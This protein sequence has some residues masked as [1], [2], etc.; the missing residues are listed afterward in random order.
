MQ[1]TQ[2][3]TMHPWDARAILTNSDVHRL[4]CMLQ[5][6]QTQ[7]GLQQPTLILQRLAGGRV[8][9]RRTVVAPRQQID[10]QTRRSVLRGRSRDF[11]SARDSRAR[12]SRTHAWGPELGRIHAWRH[13]RCGAERR[14]GRGCDSVTAQIA[15]TTPAATR[16]SD[17]YRLG[18]GERGAA[19]VPRGDAAAPR[20]VP[21]PD[22]G[23]PTPAAG[24]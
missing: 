22:R 5:Y 16:R 24:E 6:I 2:Q 21:V 7:I 17:Q 15:P 19:A 18:P 23:V 10:R 14:A 4:T 13:V 1:S 8:T 12:D 11:G 9:V 20:G 3:Q